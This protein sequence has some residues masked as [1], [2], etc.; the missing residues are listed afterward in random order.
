M[1][2]QD[3]RLQPGTLPALLRER[4]EA[5]LASGALLPIPTS[6]G[7]SAAFSESSR[8]SR[9]GFPCTT[10]FSVDLFRTAVL[11]SGP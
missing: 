3:Q 9:G 4:F 7:R 10:D 5:A 11:L 6:H 1:T 2:E 8:A